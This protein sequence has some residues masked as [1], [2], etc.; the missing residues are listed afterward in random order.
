MSRSPV[1]TYFAVALFALFTV[2]ALAATFTVTNTNDSGAGSF[3]QALL[4]ANAAAG[5][6]TIAFAISGSGVHTITPTSALPVITSPVFID[7]YTQPGSSVNT[8][9]LNAGI[10]AVLQIELTGA[11]SRLFFFTGSAGSTV[12]GLVING[13]SSDKIESWVDNTTVT[14]NFLGTNAAGTAAASGASGFGVRISQTAI[15]ATIGGPSPADRNLISGNGQG[16][17]IL[18]PSTT[19]HLIQ[20]NYVGTD[21]TGTLALSTGG[22]GMQVYGA[23]VIGNLISGNLNGGVLLIQTNVVQGNLIGT[24]R[25]GVAALPNAN[26]G[27]ININSSSGSTIGGSGAGQGNVIAFN[28]NSG[29]GFTP[30]GGSQFDRIS[31]NS[32]HSNTGLGISLFSSL[33]PF[34]ND[35]GDAD[36]VPSN[37]GQNYPVIVSA[38]IAAGT[39][40]ISGTINSN[41]STAL[42]IE[43][44]SNI[45]CDASGNGEGRTFIGATDVS[46]PPAATRASGR[47]HSRCLRARVSSRRPRPAL[48]ATPRNFRRASARLRNPM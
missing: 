34:P 44:F 47:C 43:F 32:I 7:G 5:L 14:G 45:A 35:L 23:S 24:Q 28:I 12:R 19:G 38:P 13:A 20:G 33:T 39:A 4:D 29:I 21:V 31:Q 40:T 11:Q 46:P 8:N 26:F 1:W 17:V 16:G 3:R 36:T 41:A 10:N 2:P 18:P 6:D 22:V 25:D 48:P 27:G 42:H 15:N 37:N 9:P 30:G